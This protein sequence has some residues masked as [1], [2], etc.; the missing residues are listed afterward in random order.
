MKRLLVKIFF[1]VILALGFVLALNFAYVRTNYWKSENDVYK[2]ESVPDEIEIAAIGSSHVGMHFKFDVV[3][4]LN[5]FNF[6]LMG[7]RYEDDFKIL[8]KY[9][10]HFK[11]GAV[12][13]LMIEYFEITQWV[14]DLPE[15]RPFYYRMYDREDIPNY[16]FKEDLI[17]SKLPV[18]SAKGKLMKII[19]DIPPEEMYLIS[20]PSLAKP[21]IAEEDVLKLHADQMYKMVMDRD[22]GQDGYEKNMAG[23]TKMIDFC[24]ERGFR[25][26]LVA[27]PITTYLYDR[28]AQNKEFTADYARF[29]NEVLQKYPDIKF[30]DYT[31][32]PE[33]KAD[34]NLFSDALDHLSTAGAEKFTKLVVED[35]KKN[36]LLDGN[37]K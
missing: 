13:I 2:F 24:L 7:E 27:S 23:L 29:V 8:R 5:A 11:K 12:V 17:F 15:R 14:T 19:N 3:P 35:I 32:N 21:L 6:G 18:L 16:T 1:V 28:F 9:S 37:E 26:V 10:P 4:E 33:F 36:G 30:L 25:P 20:L 22:A 34:L 31:Q